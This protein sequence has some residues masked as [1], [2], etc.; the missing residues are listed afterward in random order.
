MYGNKN[1]K[2][3]EP[4]HVE[5]YVGKENDKASFK[6]YKQ[7]SKWLETEKFEVYSNGLEKKMM[8]QCAF[9]NKTTYLTAILRPITIDLSNPPK[10]IRN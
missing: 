8:S 4:T 7:K 10:K 3:G 1:I 5:F 2:N 6:N 9:Q